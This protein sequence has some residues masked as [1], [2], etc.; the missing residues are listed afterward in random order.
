MA[1]IPH[2]NPAQ[3]F[4]RLDV[5]GD[6]TISASEIVS[7]LYENNVS[8]SKSEARVILAYFEKDSEHVFFNRY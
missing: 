6:G 8:V 3:I 7:F 5:S 1:E 4:S 2:L